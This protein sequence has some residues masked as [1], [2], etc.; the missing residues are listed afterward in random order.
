MDSYCVNRRAQESGDHEVH[1]EG[2]EFWPGA[3]NVHL[4]GSFAGCHGAVAAAKQIYPTADGCAF[5]S[6]DCHTG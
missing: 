3:G 4:L 6:P 2:C 1:K 5:C